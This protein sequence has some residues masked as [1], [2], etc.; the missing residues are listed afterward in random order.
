MIVLASGSPYRKQ[1]LLNL[2]IEFEVE[3]PRMDE[4]SLKDPSLGPEKLCQTLARAKAESLLE[5]RPKDTLIGSDQLVVCQGEILGKAGSKERAIQQLSKLSGKTHRL[6]TSLCVIHQGQ[7]IEHLD[8]TQL[9]MRDWNTQ[10]LSAY[11]QADQ[12]LDCAGSYK[13]ES[14]GLALFSEIQSQDHSAIIGLPL[15]ALCRILWELK[16]PLPFQK[17]APHA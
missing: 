12:S 13:L 17:E 2:G 11:V 7:A 5:A 8:E 3:A 10:E 6:L 16:I 9:T 14:Q 4:E 15:L 1:Q